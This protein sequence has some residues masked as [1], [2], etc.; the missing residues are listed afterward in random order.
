LLLAAMVIRPTDAWFI[1]FLP[2][3]SLLCSF[4]GCDTQPWLGWWLSCGVVLLLHNIFMRCEALW[5]N[6]SPLC[7]SRVGLLHL[8]LVMSKFWT[9]KSVSDTWFTPG[10]LLTYHLTPA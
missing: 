1:G 10:W 7:M 2:Y 8:I 4:S 9:N 6:L 3:L 5:W